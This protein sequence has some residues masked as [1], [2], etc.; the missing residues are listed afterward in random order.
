VTILLCG[1]DRT[2]MKSTI[3]QTRRRGNF[4]HFR[5]CAGVVL[6]SAIAQPATFN[7][8]DGD[9]PGLL[10]AINAANAAVGADTINL[11]PGGLYTLVAVGQFDSFTGDTGLPFVTSPLTINGNG[12]TIARSSAAGV[13]DFRVIFAVVSDLTL[14]SVTITGGRGGASQRDG[15]GVGIIGGTLI[16]RNS[17]VTGNTALL[18]GGGGIAA[19]VSTL[20]VENSTISYNTGS[21]GRTGGGI[22][23]S[24]GIMTLISNSTIFEN[25]ATDGRGDAIA[26]AFSPLGSVIVK[27]SILASPTRGVGD[28]CIFFTPDSRGHNIASDATCQLSATGDMNG[29]DP[30]LGL[31]A[32]NG[33]P[34][35]THLPL[36]GSPAIDAI[37]VA[38]CTNIDG[39]PVS[40]DQ[41]GVSRPQGAGCDIGSVDVSEAPDF[42]VCLLYDP[43]KAVKSGATIPIKLQ[44]CDASGANLS[45]ADIAVVAT[46]LTQVSSSI[47]GPVED[48]GNANPDFNFRF[49]ET[50]GDTGGYIFNLKTTGLSTGTY[51][52]NFTIG[53]SP[54]NYVA[55]IQVK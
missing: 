38:A 46:S 26:D 44:I 49:D 16:V 28:D 47:S 3:R 21:G 12:A 8:A 15:G 30:M 25:Q 29:T 27:N 54:A 50:L 40:T 43:D 2:I 48:S 5:L 18:D 4:L 6:A 42:L 20:H 22:L 35:P 7:V 11:A 41:R 52:V 1:L 39:V 55:P 33:G 9:V 31:L 34:T 10:A 37:P 32:F 24:S 13:P 23:H 19:Y 14:D 51:H 36:T 45:S 53:D 17:T